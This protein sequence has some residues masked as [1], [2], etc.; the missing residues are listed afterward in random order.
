MFAINHAATALIVKSR[1]RDAPLIPLLVSVQVVELLWVAFN[2]TPPSHNYTRNPGPDHCHAIRSRMAGR[3][4]PKTVADAEPASC[5]SKSRFA[6]WNSKN[7]S[8]FPKTAL[9]LIK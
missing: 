9:H 2:G 3:K 4:Q 5:R 7:C 1:Y 6:L 8:G